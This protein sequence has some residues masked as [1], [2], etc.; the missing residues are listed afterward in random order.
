M[1]LGGRVPYYKTTSGPKYF[2]LEKIC[3]PDTGAQNLRNF[4]LDFGWFA[5]HVL[6]KMLVS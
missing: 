4:G 6:T 3:L 2:L 5:S 1:K